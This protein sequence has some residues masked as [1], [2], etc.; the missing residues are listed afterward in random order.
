MI[1]RQTVYE[2]VELQKKRGKYIFFLSDVK[3]ALPYYDNHN[4]TISLSRLIKQKIII[5]PVREFYVIIPTEYALTGIIDPLF[6]IDKMMS[7]LKR[8]YYI[9]LLNAAEF[10]GASH[11]RPQTFTI[12]NT[13]PDIRDSK[14]GGIPFVFICKKEIPSAFIEQKKAKLGHLNVSSPELTAIDLIAFENK[15]GGLNRVCS[16]INDLVEVIDFN[17]IKPEYFLIY[18]IPIYQRL[19]YILEFIIGEKE[20]ADCLFKD[21]KSRNLRFRKI[22]F[23]VGVP[24]SGSMADNRWNVIKNLEIEIDE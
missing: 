16:V 5:S 21:M 11:Q 14:R 9:G 13:Y 12:M 1:N 19:G 6:Y 23:K 18:P 20:L 24:L 4:I 3:N 2:W 7:F 15:I 8:D 17:K 22:P 10:Y